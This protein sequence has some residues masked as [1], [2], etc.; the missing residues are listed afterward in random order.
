[1]FKSKS[2]APA[3]KFF[4]TAAACALAATVISA[5]AQT[6]STGPVI[7]LAPAQSVKK[8]TNGKFAAEVDNGWVIYQGFQGQP[9]LNFYD[10]D[11]SG[12]L[13]LVTA[14]FGAGGAGLFFDAGGIVFGPCSAGKNRCEPNS[15]TGATGVGIGFGQASFGGPGGE[16]GGWV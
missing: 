10:T 5:D 7:A 2:S 3:V 11:I 8:V 16:A 4:L 14:G 15:D 1:M 6:V 9:T 12:S 13:K